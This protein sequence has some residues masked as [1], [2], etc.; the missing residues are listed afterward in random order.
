M[1]GFSQCKAVKADGER[2]RRTAQPDKMYCYHHRH[3]PQFRVPVQPSLFEMMEHHCLMCADCGHLIPP[4]KA[5]ALAVNT[6]PGVLDDVLQ[7]RC[8]PCDRLRQQIESR[9]A[10]ICADS[11][12]GISAEEIYKDLERFGVDQDL[13]EAARLRMHAD[14][15]LTFGYKPRASEG[16]A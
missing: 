2:C 15:R 14:G 4:D 1:T 10:E 16:S 13:V 7:V 3:Q 12:H 9:I 11:P 8:E 6:S 5:C